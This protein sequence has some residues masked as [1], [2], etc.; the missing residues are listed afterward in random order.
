MG[1]RLVDAGLVGG[2]EGL[3]GPGVAIGGVV[4]VGQVGCPA[5]DAVRLGFVAAFTVERSAVPLSRVM[6][7]PSP[8]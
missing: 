4:D 2:L 3:A 1:A 8:V 7:A 6:T 5:L